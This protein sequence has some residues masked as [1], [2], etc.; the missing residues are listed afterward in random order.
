MVWISRVK[1]DQFD[2]AGPVAHVPGYDLSGMGKTIGFDDR[3]A[4]VY[5]ICATPIKMVQIPGCGI[6][7][8]N[9]MAVLSI[10]GGSNQIAIHGSPS[11]YL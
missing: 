6:L 5:A 1:L 11:S 9:F 2:D 7:L 8:N 4:A 10:M 3:P